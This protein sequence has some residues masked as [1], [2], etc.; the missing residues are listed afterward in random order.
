MIQLSEKQKEIVESSANKILVI[1]S[2][3]VGKTACIAARTRFLLE[4]G[5]PASQM[6]VITFTIAAAQEMK[7]RI[8]N[9]EGLFVGTIH[10]LVYQWLCIGGYKYEADKYVETEDFD[11]FFSL[12]KKHPECARHL[13]TLIIDE[14]Q[15]VSDNMWFTFFEL[16]QPNNF[17]IVGDPNQSIYSFRNVNPN[18]LFEISKWKDVTTYF[19][20]ENYRNSKHILAFAKRF[21]KKAGMDMDDTSIPMN[22][23]S[24]LVI[25]GKYSKENLEKLLP[26][27]SNYGDWF[28]LARTN[29]AADEIEYLLNRHKIPCRRLVRAGLSQSE[30]AKI[31]KEDK[32]LVG[33][34]H[35]AKG[36][37]RHGVIVCGPWYRKPEEY[38]LNYVAAT[39]AENVLVWLNNAPKTK[40]GW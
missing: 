7:E 25:E 32:I 22:P 35:S 15:D 37:E 16:I 11:K 4:N 34:I 20:N 8:G 10:A 9:Y 31:M 23:N 27:I 26:K 38:R 21:L 24:G 28:I 5:A 1:S 3:A 39:R 36:L 13:D 29:A 14:A 12:L 17:F 2:A 33:T 18:K 6:A 30:L 19:L 40:R